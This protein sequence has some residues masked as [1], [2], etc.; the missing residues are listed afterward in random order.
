MSDVVNSAWNYTVFYGGSFH[1]SPTLPVDCVGSSYFSNLVVAESGQVVV[2]SSFIA[3]PSF[4]AHVFHIVGMS[5][6]EQVALIN[7]RTDITAVQDLKSVGYA[8]VNKD[9][10]DSVG[11][12]HLPV[13]PELA[14]ALPGKGT[15][16]WNALVRFLRDKFSKVFGVSHGT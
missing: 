1:P 13:I 16:P 10:G 15:I 4:C 6:G 8:A 7:A 9:V 12:T 14:V 3:C 5:A 2:A 11:L